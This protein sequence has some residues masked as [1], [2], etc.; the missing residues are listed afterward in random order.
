MG[1]TVEIGSGLTADDRVVESP[2]DGLAT[3]DEV[4]IANS[5]ATGAET[6]AKEQRRPPG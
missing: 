5:P 4:R 2:Q 3:G 1:R 6:V